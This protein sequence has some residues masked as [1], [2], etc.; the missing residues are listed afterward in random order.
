MVKKAIKKPAKQ[1][2]P[3]SG[4]L[5]EPLTV[6][7]VPIRQGKHTFYVFS[8]DASTLWKF[9]SISRRHEMKDEGYQRVLSTSRVDAAARYIQD[10][11]P[12]PN[13]VLLA[14][15]GASFEEKTNEL[16]IPAGSDIGWVIDGQHRIAGAHEAAQSA[17]GLDIELCV[18][19][20]IDV[21]LEFQITQ[22]VNINREAK[23][24][25][26]S[27]VYDLLAHLPPT[28]KPS[29]IATERATDIANSLRKDPD[30]P[31]YRRIVVTTS[32]TKGREL[33]ITNFVRKVSPLVHPERGQLKIYTQ[34]EMQRIVSNYYSA[35]KLTFPEQWKFS[36]NMFFR[37]VGFGALFNV[38]D[39]IF[40]TV[41]SRYGNFRIESVVEVLEPVKHFDFQQWNSYGTGNKAELQAAQDFR[42]DFSRSKP[43]NNGG[44]IDLG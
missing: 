21:D 32:P 13:S 28:R 6:S 14:L 43:A 27:L 42:V 1:S 16:T 41:L 9:V 35:L 33:S 37:T 2:D 12:I 30:S 5:D 31:F 23:G 18:A 25:P 11:N 19:A 36:D 44:N 20:F 38:F 7:A 39:D 10:G 3:K 17:N 34:P 29:A 8:L 24:V 15:D 40:Q 22:F 4:G 26:T